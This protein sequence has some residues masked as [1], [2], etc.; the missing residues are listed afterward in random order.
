MTDPTKPPGAIEREL[1]RVE[2]VFR[3]V[4]PCL[5]C[6]DPCTCK[7]P[8]PAG[9]A[10]QPYTSGSELRDLRHALRMLDSVLENPFNLHR[11]ANMEEALKHLDEADRTR[12]VSIHR[13]AMAGRRR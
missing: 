7:P 8:P 3:K 13:Q 6:G 10:S 12:I 2:D 4:T 5:W 1:E 9:S 11:L